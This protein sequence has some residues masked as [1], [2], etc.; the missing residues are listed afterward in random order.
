MPALSLSMPGSKRKVIIAFS[1]IGLLLSGHTVALLVADWRL[2]WL[3]ASLYYAAWI[4]ASII[5]LV[6][7]EELRQLFRSDTHRAWYLLPSILALPLFLYI[8]IPNRHVFELDGLLAFHILLCL[9]NPFL[10]EVYWRGLVS[11]F[12]RNPVVSFLV[13]TT[14]FAAG[15]PLIFGVNSVGASGWIA[16]AGTWIAGA[17]LWV[18]YYKTKSL[19]GCVLAHLLID[20]AG[21]G[22]YVLANK[23]QLIEFAF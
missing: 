15:H 14:G 20:V 16:F 22:A 19:R 13:S 4:T 9:I 21:M 23:L 5:L 6:T 3:Y 10:E 8:F 18:C 2:G 1:I 12:S 17:A 7:S 11:K